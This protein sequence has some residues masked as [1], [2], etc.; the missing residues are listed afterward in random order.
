M[1]DGGECLVGLIQR[2]DCY[3]R[4]QV[5]VGCNVE[6]IACVGS[7]HICHAADLA[8]AP[9]QPVVIELWNAVKMDRVDGDN[10]S[11]SQAGKSG[12]YDI[13]AGGEGYRAVEFDGRLVCFTANPG[14]AQ[15][16]G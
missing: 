13:S 5:N 9:E 1:S 8:L 2:E 12:D 3:L 7:S 10:A 16:S 15:G 14:G 6:K 11:F 4:L